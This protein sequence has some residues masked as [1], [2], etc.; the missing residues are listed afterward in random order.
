MLGDRAPRVFTS[1]QRAGYE[2]T[3]EIMLQ[4]SELLFISTKA[5]TLA[6]YINCELETCY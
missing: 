3:P 5:P 1:Q 2:S 4:N 6:V